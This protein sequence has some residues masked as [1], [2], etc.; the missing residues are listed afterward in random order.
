[1]A[2]V[3][4]SYNLPNIVKQVDYIQ[5]EQNHYLKNLKI[6]RQEIAKMLQIIHQIKIY[7]L[8]STH[9]KR[10]GSTKKG[11]GQTWPIKQG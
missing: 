5:A 11:Y 8:N 7:T 1:M 4:E 10:T 2:N 9:M 6:Y 3:D